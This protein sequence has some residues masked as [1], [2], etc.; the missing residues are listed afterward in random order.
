[1]GEVGAHVLE[2]QNVG[3]ELGEVVGVLSDALGLLRELLVAHVLGDDLL[4]VARC[5][6]AGAGGDD[7]G[8]PL[9]VEH[10]LEGLDM[11]AGDLRGVFEVAGVGV[12]LAAADLVFREDDLVAEAFKQGHCSLGSLGEHDVCQAGGKESDAHWGILPRGCC[13]AQVMT[14]SEVPATVFVQTTEARSI[15]PL[16]FA[17]KSPRVINEN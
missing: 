6:G 4:L 2:T 16:F 13:P 1:M 8:V 15:Y 3:D 7:D 12:H 9:A 14:G 10:G 11:V 17:E 5:T